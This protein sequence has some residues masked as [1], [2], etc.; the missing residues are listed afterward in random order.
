MKKVLIVEDSADV[1]KIVSQKLSNYSIEILEAQ[2]GRQAWDVIIK[3]HP[4]LIILDVHI[5][6]MDGLEILSEMKNEWIDTPVIIMSGDDS[7]TIKESCY[8][9]GAKGYISKPI[10]PNAIDNIVREYGLSA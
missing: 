3:S 4:D 6:Y 9:L 8:L 5:P 1:R 7:V 2:D 10:P